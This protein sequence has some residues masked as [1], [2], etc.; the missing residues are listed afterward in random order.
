[1]QATPAQLADLEA[2]DP[3]DPGAGQRGEQLGGAGRAGAPVVRHRLHLALR[4]RD[5]VLHDEPAS[6]E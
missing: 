5:G 4:P 6:V 1:M 2:A 3:L